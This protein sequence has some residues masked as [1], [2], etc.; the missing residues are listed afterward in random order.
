MATAAPKAISVKAYKAAIEFI[1]GY[2]APM[3]IR[4]MAAALAP[5]EDQLAARLAK[6]IKKSRAQHINLRDVR[7]GLFGPVGDLSDSAKMKKAAETL[8]AASLI[9]HI[10]VR[11][12]GK[13]GRAPAL[14]EVNPLLLQQEASLAS[15][16]PCRHRRL[17]RAWDRRPQLWRPKVHRWFWRSDFARHDPCQAGS[18]DRLSAQSPN[19]LLRSRAR[20]GRQ[21][22]E[23]DT[24]PPWGCPSLTIF[25]LLASRQCPARPLEHAADSRGDQPFERNAF[26]LC[27]DG[28]CSS[29][30]RVFLS[31]HRHLG[32]DRG[33]DCVDGLC[34]HR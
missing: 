6:L 7:R 29:R 33:R 28:L 27:V 34:S 14:Y 15:G 24:G 8:E 4:T 30:V 18:S 25:K 11:A 22:G 20:S 32:P 9:R 2:A 21:F 12:D 23:R 17:G 1:D 31:V 3:A 13:A 16:R 5:P 26:E 10:G 19:A